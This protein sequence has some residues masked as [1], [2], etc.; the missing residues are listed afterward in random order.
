[1]SKSGTRALNGMGSIRKRKDGSYEGRYTGSDGRQHSVY[2]KTPKACGEALRAATHSVDNG[3]WLEPSTMSMSQWF[4]TWLRDYQGHTTGRTV[5]TYKA[6]IDKHMRPAF[7]NVK[8]AAFSPV[9]VRRMVSEMTKAGKSPATIQHARGILSACM[10]CAIEAGIR[11][12]NPVEKVKGPRLV[13]NEFAIV[14]REH[15]PAF[16]KAAK[17]TPVPNELIFLLFTGLRVG[18]LRGLRWSDIDLDAATLRVER[19]LR[20][21]NRGDRRIEP[22]KDGE[23][24]TIHLAPQAVALLKQQRKDQASARLAAGADW[25]DDE[26]T[27]DLVF[28]TSTGWNLAQ[29]TIGNAVNHIREPLNMPT[30]RPHDLRHSYAVAA[31]RSGVDVKTVQHNLGHKHAS[32]TLD[33]YAAYT[34]DAGKIGAE[35]LA[36]Y[37]QDAIK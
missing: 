16:I 28:R 19:Q 12:D 4:D 9:H 18:E 22:P 31:L 26:I 15:I 32:I 3:S 37:W 33:I 6:V 5:D 29:S 2:A 20:Q 11:N 35:K 21:L 10:N 1:M 36:A 13:K 34:D 24:R 14:D 27:R 30:L 23:V 8:V 7:G 25:H 17:N